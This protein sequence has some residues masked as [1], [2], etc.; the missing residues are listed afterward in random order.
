M[1]RKK[2]LTAALCLCTAL[3]AFTAAFPSGAAAVESKK[4]TV[5]GSKYSIASPSYTE[6][7]INYLQNGSED[8]LVPQMYK[9]TGTVL[10]RNGIALPVS[11]SSADLGYVTPVKDQGNLN[12]CWVF[13]AMS[14]LETY[15]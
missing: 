12:T 10:K 2:R 3:F 15:L 7:Y 8:L 5:G 6:E 11:Y 4:F 9:S 1:K 14:G 13:G